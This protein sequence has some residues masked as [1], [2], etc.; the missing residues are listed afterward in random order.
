MKIFIILLT[1]TSLTAHAQK[2]LSPQA[3]QANIR[4]ALSGIMND[5]NQMITLFPDFPKD[6]IDINEDLGALEIEKEQ[7]RDKCPRLINQKCAD[8][9]YSIQKKLAGLESRTMK[10]IA[11]QKMPATLPMTNIGG[12]RL[13]NEFQADLEEIKGEIDNSSFMLKAEVAHRKESYD[14]VKKLD[15][16]D[17]ML[18]LAIVEFVPY[19]YQEDF[20]QF[21]SNFVH[22]IHQ[23]ITQSRNYEFMNRN[24]MALNFSLNLLNMNLTKRNKKTPEGMG[25]FL[26]LMHNRWNSILRYYY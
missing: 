4:P 17:T 5:F 14:V 3:F 6:I 9:V 23:H 21:Y 25:P 13:V 15:V 18:S 20:R 2:T 26:A 1:W 22:P 10:L 11:V 24:I 8:I 16:L 12:M 7:L 19:L